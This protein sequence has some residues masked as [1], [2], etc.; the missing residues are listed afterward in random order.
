MAT[1]HIVQEETGERW[2]TPEEAASRINV[3]VDFVRRLIREK[4]IPYAKF[5][6]AKN[7][8]VRISETD[9]D[10]YVASCKVEAV[11]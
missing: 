2:F 10:A 4:R 9:L 7:G 6:L 8:R 11:R 1:T 5:G 3:S